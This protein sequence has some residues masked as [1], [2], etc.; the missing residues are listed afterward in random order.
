MSQSVAHTSPPPSNTDTPDAGP[1][2]VAIITTTIYPSASASAAP[3]PASSPSDVPIAAIAGGA[4]AGIFLAIAAVLVWHL[5]G[6]SIK[7]KEDEEKK[8]TV[9]ALPGIDGRC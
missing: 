8:E 7:H 4:A 3:A 6:R 1:A 2:P 5:W 9:R